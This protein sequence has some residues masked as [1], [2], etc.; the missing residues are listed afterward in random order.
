MSGLREF[1]QK[2]AG[3]AVAIVLLLLGLAAAWW[4]ISG[5]MENPVDDANTRWFVDSTTLQPFRHELKAGEMI[6]VQAPSGGKTGY[7]A[8]LCYWTA[9]GKV[10]EEPTPVLLNSSLGKSE[11]TF[12]P[13]CGR[14]VVGRN[15]PAD[16]SRRPPPKK[17][18]MR[19]GGDEG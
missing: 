4:S 19:S 12:C 13:D 18:E 5:S 10:K 14:L 15:P 1:F 6:P 3:Q 2:P 16:A 11:P 17:E 9:D 7:L 8:E